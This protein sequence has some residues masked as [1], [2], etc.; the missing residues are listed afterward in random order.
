MA[1]V[2]I[3]IVVAWAFSLLIAMDHDVFHLHS[4]FDCLDKWRNQQ[5]KIKLCQFLLKE[6]ASRPYSKTVTFRPKGKNG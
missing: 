5:Q 6:H 1:H 2:A 4:P 3:Q